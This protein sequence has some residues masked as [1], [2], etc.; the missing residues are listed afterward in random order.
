MPLLKKWI[1]WFVGNGSRVLIGQNPFVVCGPLFK[2]S[3]ALIQ[4]LKT[5]QVFSLAHI[6]FHYV[7]NEFGSVDWLAPEY[8]GL[9]GDLAT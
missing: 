9:V 7:L 4:F 1:V 5:L 6:G 3:T 2:L 8:L